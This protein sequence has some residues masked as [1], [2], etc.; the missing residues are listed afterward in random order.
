MKEP[1]IPET[2][3]SR[4]NVLTSIEVLD[5]DEEERFNRLTRIAKM[6]FDVPIALVSLIDENRQWFKSCLGLDVRQT[7]R[8]ISFC[9]HAILKNEIF[10]IPDTLSDERFYDNPLVIGN[11]Y[12]RFYAGCPLTVHNSR[13]G[14]LCIIDNKPRQFSAEN[15]SVLKDIG[16]LVESELMALQLSTID[17]LTGVQNRRGFT[18]LIQSGIKVCSRHKICSTLVYFDLDKFKKINDEY[19]HNEGDVALKQFSKS[20]INSSR[21]SDIIGRLGGDEFTV[22]LSNSNMETSKLYLQRLRD[23]I[24]KWNAESKKNWKI[25]YSSGMI[26]I[27]PDTT[28]TMEALLH[29]ADTLMYEAKQKAT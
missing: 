12:I 27:D 5:T 16:K 20:L 1:A 19:G 17:E 24:E 29:E 22:W 26:Q 25:Q 15:L 18:Q 14:T 3:I 8:N 9:G 4:L 7:P 23:E 2:E 10:I 13:I 11:P 6:A 28:L 21:D